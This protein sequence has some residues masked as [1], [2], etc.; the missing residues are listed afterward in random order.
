MIFA[1]SCRWIDETGIRAGRG[2]GDERDKPGSEYVKVE[3]VEGR[4]KGM[5]DVGS[6]SN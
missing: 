5:V 6:R 1:D 4:V 2:S 3:R